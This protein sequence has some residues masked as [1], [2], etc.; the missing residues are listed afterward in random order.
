[1]NSQ[2]DCQYDTVLPNIF[3]TNYGTGSFEENSMIKIE[4]S[5]EI[6]GHEYVFALIR[7]DNGKNNSRCHFQIKKD[8]FDSLYSDVM[9]SIFVDKLLRNYNSGMVGNSREGFNNLIAGLIPDRIA[10]EEYDCYM[11]LARVFGITN[12]IGHYLM[13]FSSF[14]VSM[15]FQ[16]ENFNASLSGFVF[17]DWNEVAEWEKPDCNQIIYITDES[18]KER[19]N[20]LDAVYLHGFCGKIQ[21]SL[22]QNKQYSQYFFESRDLDNHHFNHDFPESAM[23]L[24]KHV[25]DNLRRRFGEQKGE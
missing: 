3:Y 11:D 14:Q 25:N 6:D 4:V 13:D 2:D 12:S 22:E 16:K 5:R 1:M 8:S 21:L 23:G 15:D 24:K 10:E 9:D 19:R 20:D 7:H 18:M 17:L